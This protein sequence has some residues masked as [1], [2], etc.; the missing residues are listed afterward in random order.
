MLE[1][2]T[3]IRTDRLVLRPAR[4]GDLAAIH[5]IL[6]DPRAMA[7]WST[8]P[9]ESLDQSR[10]WL[11]G[12]LHIPA[13]QGEDYVV[14]LHGRVIGKAG[15]Y[16][17]PEIGFIFAP[18]VWGQGYAREALGALIAR[19]FGPLGQDHIIADVDPRNA[20]CL[21]LLTRLGFHET[22]RA[23]KTWQ[24]GESWSDSVYLRLD[25]PAD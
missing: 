13:D 17:F 12:M 25:A 18:D 5:A 9:H 2:D 14:E 1:I 24:I 19:A 10:D 21:G 23:E 16:R 7:Y 20:A 15:L 22:G 6:S 11:E 4:K 8:L 3:E